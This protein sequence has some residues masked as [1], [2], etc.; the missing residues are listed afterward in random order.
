MMIK[1][2]WIFALALSFAAVMMTACGG[3]EELIW[4]K[5]P[6][7]SRAVFLG[8]TAF[9]DPVPIALDENGDVY[10]A[11]F[12]K[13]EELTT[14]HFRIKALDRNADTLWERT[15]T[16]IPLQ[17]PD[18]TQLLW[19]EG[20]LRL[21]WIEQE[22]LY[23]LDLQTDGR[24]FSDPVLLSG[25][26]PVGSYDV[27]ADSKGNLTLWY[28]G[29]REA[30]G[31][32]ALTSFD[33][34]SPPVRIDPE[35]VRIQLRYAQNDTLHTSWAHYP[36]GY[37]T[38]EIL[39]A[40]YP[41]GVDWGADR[42]SVVYERAV[43]PT[44]SLKGPA[45]GVDE[46]DIYLFWTVVIRTGMEAG[47]VQTE[48]VYFPHAQPA[49]VSRPQSI[50]MPSVY[51]LEHERLPNARL[52]AGERVDLQD[53]NIPRTVEL[54]EITP[55]TRTTEELAI[56]FRSPTQHLWR[57]ERYQI[58]VAYF[59]NGSPSSYQPLSFTPALSTAPNLISSDKS[60][61]YITW[62]EK[63][64]ADWYSVYFA[65]T[66]PAVKS[67][68]SRSTGRELLQL[69]AQISFGLLVGIL[70]APIGAVVWSLAP[71]FL[72]LISAPLRNLGSSRTRMAFTVISVLGAV[73]VYWVG[74]FATLPGMMD[75]VPFSA[76][77]PTISLALGNILR[78]VVPVLILGLAAA[79]A[80]NY[81][82][83]RSHRSTLYFLLIYIGIDAL[84]TAAI[85]AVLIY[86]AI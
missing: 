12:E 70:L 50:A 79:V 3:P 68:L 81:T 15:L 41:A 85:Y 62:L 57:K 59:R 23:G 83:R 18:S 37:G 51:Y 34:S 28:A 48:Y 56:S 77:I 72:L 6:G 66:S 4:L 73:A 49:A 14:A 22:R 9:N 13:G 31:V 27:A 74:K 19:D 1:K 46:T 67:A 44:N 58:N 24:P 33:G 43:S 86:G 17:G 47:A 21:F 52:S 60:H 61:L 69:V 16:D 53:A 36:L 20:G 5:S 54:Q 45:L 35:G 29:T 78:R 39:Y 38:S 7:W 40:A 42:Y 71:M 25:G 76:W 84:L 30:P 75:Y 11:L 10:F 2:H 82:F 55:D 26:Q 80:W 8:K 63:Q 32:Y 64:Q 65:S